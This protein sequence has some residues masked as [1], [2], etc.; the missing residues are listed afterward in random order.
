MKM[1]DLMKWEFKN[2]IRS[3]AFWG[4]GIAFVLCT[5]LFLLIPLCEGGHTGYQLY[6]ENL[7][8]FNSLMLFLAGI[9]AGIHITGAFEDRKIQSA[10]MAGNTR[11]SILITKAVSFFVAMAAFFISSVG[12]STLVAFVAVGAGDVEGSFFVSVIVRGSVLMLADISF[13]SICLVISMLIRNQGAS[14]TINL[15]SLILLYCGSEALFGI[16]WCAKL[17]RYT[18]VGQMLYL[19]SDVSDGNL[20]TACAVSVVGIIA[21]VGVSYI[22]FAKEELK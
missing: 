19:F 8:N 1:N 17:L 16:E 5:I 10:V 13:V 21:A 6:L 11:F 20:M 18:P 22:K 14:I 3:K 15:L 9:F 7:N 2:L 12:I 4:M